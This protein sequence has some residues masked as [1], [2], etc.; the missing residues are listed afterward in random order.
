[1]GNDTLIS[2]GFLKINLVSSYSLKRW[3]YYTAQDKANVWMFKFSSEQ[4]LEF[5]VVFSLA[6]VT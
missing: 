6:H 2:L 1:M 5:Q 3:I 4:W